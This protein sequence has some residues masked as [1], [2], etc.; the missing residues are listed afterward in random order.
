MIYSC[1]SQHLQF[2][3]A[4]ITIAQSSHICLTWNGP[5][6][7]CFFAYWTLNIHILQ[8]PRVPMQFNYW[9]FLPLPESGLSPVSSK[10]CLV[11]LPH[12]TLLYSWAASYTKPVTPHLRTF[13]TIHHSPC[14]PSVPVQFSWLGRALCL[15]NGVHFNNTHKAKT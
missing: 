12:G 6:Y 5:G 10:S 2:L 1:E 4:L 3:M 14:F 9:F 11:P 8:T 13:P 15:G 7:Y